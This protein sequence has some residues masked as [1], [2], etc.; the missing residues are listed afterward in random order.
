MKLN[1]N[2]QGSGG[3]DFK[4]NPLLIMSFGVGA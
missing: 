4:L 1:W 2:V 3:G